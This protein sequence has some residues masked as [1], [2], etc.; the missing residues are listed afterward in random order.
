MQTQKITTCLA[1]L[2]AGVC[3]AL[4]AAD[5][6]DTR[7]QSIWD[8]ASKE[9]R[10]KL[11]YDLPK[12]GDLHDHFGGANIPDWMLA[13]AK[14]P[15]RRGEEIFWTRLHFASP[16]DAI[17][18]RAESHV[19]RNYTYEKLPPAVKAE[20]VRMDQMTPEEEEEWKDA[21]RLDKAGEGRDEFFGT[22]W[23]RFGDL[24]TS[25]A[26]RMELLADNIKAFAAEGL[27]YLELQYSAGGLVAL[28]G[29]PYTEEECVQIVEDRLAQ[30]DIVETGMEV[31]FLKTIL[32]FAPN[33]EDRAR[34]DY[35]F[36]D[37]HRDRWVGMNMAGI[38][39]NGH[40]Y[41]LRFLEVFRELRAEYPTL[42]LSFHAGEM[43][44]PDKHIHDTL[45][46]GASRIGHG[47]NI[48]G[49]PETYLLMRMSKDVLIEIN[50][51]SNQ[52]LEYVDDIK[53]HP[54]P[55]LLRTGVPVCLNTDDRGM[56]D[57]NMTDEYYTAMTVFNLSWPELTVLAENSL[58]FSFIQEEVK[59][60]LL[61]DYAERIEAFEAKYSKG[62]IE[63]ALAKVDAIDAV[64][65]G[66]AKEKWGITFE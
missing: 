20:Y 51:I 46:L 24:Y 33:A 44:G 40:G 50:L 47:I 42:K 14:D 61:K 19:V 30:P 10:F 15:E 41:P 21:F 56:W 65:Y 12:G 37:A 4:N 8:A 52:L 60:E 11:L 55:E 32:R 16:D 64:T 48:L 35:A 36:V 53:K 27:S 7:F 38:E 57:S 28:D 22:M 17:S 2:I 43:D 5:S 58:K 3:A 18:P 62:S 59:A 66:Y 39:E 9:Q 13:I 54:F 25:P 1:F 23:H 6:F 29:T 31:R 34:A 49:D 26:M 63:D 45:L